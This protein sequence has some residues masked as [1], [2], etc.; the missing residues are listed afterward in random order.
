MRRLKSRG[1]AL[2]ALAGDLG[3]SAGPTLAGAIAGAAGDNLR[4]GILCG[5]GFPLLLIAGLAGLKR[6]QKHE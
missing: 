3:C 2:L 4:L 5:V 1:L 6:L